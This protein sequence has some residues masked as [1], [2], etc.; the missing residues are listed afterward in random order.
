ML[1]SIALE[2]R[3]LRE[4]FEPTLNVVKLPPPIG[5]RL[6]IGGIVAGGGLKIVDRVARKL[7]VRIGAHTLRM[8]IVD[9]AN[10]RKIAEI[11]ARRGA[12]GVCLSLAYARLL[13]KT[14]KADNFEL[15]TRL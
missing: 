14:A 7:C 13:V 1:R 8:P 10:E 11:F 9:V 3:A 6:L 2:Q 5:D 12:K 4:R 15:M